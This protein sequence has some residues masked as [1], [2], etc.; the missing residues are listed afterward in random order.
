MRSFLVGGLQFGGFLA[1]V[2]LMTY[3]PLYFFG[4]VSVYCFVGSFLGEPPKATF[5]V[6][7]F[8]LS[9]LVLCVACLYGAAIH[10]WGE[11]EVLRALFGLRYALKHS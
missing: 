9:M 5:G 8:R 2:A 7:W 1:I 6:F 3:L 10:I 4:V 11:F